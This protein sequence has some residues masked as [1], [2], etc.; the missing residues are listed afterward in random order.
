MSEPFSACRLWHVSERRCKRIVIWPWC[1][2]W[3]LAELNRDFFY[4]FSVTT[5]TACDAKEH[6]KP[7]CHWD[8]QPYCFTTDYL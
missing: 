1:E 4:I 5:L 8:S 6:K 7:S 2:H 3:P